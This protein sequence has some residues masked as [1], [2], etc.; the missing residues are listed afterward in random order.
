[1]GGLSGGDLGLV[2][3][4]VRGERAVGRVDVRLEGW[5]GGDV[6]DEVPAAPPEDARHERVVHAV[7]YALHLYA[8]VDLLLSVVGPRVHGFEERVLALPLFVG[9]AY[10]E[11][12]GDSG[13][14]GWYWLG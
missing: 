2:R 4:H 12:V 1:M 6:G 8:Y 5:V 7:E 13:H 14:L 3:A 9:F 11:R 10:G